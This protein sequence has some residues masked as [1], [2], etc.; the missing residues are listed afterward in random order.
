MPDLG[1][2]GSA[3]TVLA[4]DQSLVASIPY[5]GSLQLLVTPAPGDPLLSFGM[6]H[7]RECVCTRVRARTHTESFLI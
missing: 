1:K 4:E 5:S 3:L 7:E 2:D 6:R